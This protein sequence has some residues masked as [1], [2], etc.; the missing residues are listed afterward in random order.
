MD[1]D[2]ILEAIQAGQFD[3]LTD[4]QLAQGRAAIRESLAADLAAK[5]AGEDRPLSTEEFTALRVAGEAVVA[6][7][8]ARA[9]KAA[10]AAAGDEKASDLVASLSDPTPESEVVEPAPKP[11]LKAINDGKPAQTE[12]EPEEVVEE[13]G[14]VLVAASGAPVS[15]FAGDVATQDG[16]RISTRAELGERLMSLHRSTQAPPDGSRSMQRAAHLSWADSV[17]QFS[18]DEGHNLAVAAEI[19]ANE[20]AKARKDISAGFDATLALQA[21]T[22]ICGPAEVRYEEF[23]LGS[24]TAGILNLPSTTLTRGKLTVPDSLTYDDLR[25]TSG[26][27]FP[28]DSSDGDGTHGVVTKACWTVPCGT[29]RDFELKAEQSCFTLSNFLGMFNPERAAHA[30]SQG[31]MAHAHRVNKRLIA[32]LEADT[33]TVTNSSTDHGGGAIVNFFRD[34]V[35]A[36]ALYRDKYRLNQSDVLEVLAPYGVLP[37]LMVDGITRPNAEANGFRVAEAIS[38]LQSE[39]NIRV[40]FLYDWTGHEMVANPGGFGD[41]GQSILIFPAGSVLH[42]TAATLDLGEV[43]DSTLNSTN[44]YSVWVETFDGIVVLG[45]EVTHI[46]DGVYCPSGQ[47][48]AENASINCTAS[49]GS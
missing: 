49:T 1:L 28:Y 47:V 24:A 42:A 30:V 36:A 20:Q 13:A 38:R 18:S 32:E 35:H 29:T 44:D 21:A 40:Q 27:A 10:E 22:G 31:L 37:A 6:E 25:E 26:I 39:N 14:A 19:Y 4:E 12:L 41:Q 16:P 7:V 45:P 5:E 43:R 3:S 23:E 17:H 33:R 11:T 2:Q 8:A 48:G 15:P 9:E 46:D 34:V